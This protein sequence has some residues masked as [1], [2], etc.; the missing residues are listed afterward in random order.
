M[1]AKRVS[2]LE[3]ILLK[4]TCTL[5]HSLFYGTEFTSFWTNL[6]VLAKE[7]PFLLAH[8]LKSAYLSLL[9]FA[10]NLWKLICLLPN[11]VGN[12]WTPF[13]HG[14]MFLLYFFF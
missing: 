13:C 10:V 11:H 5:V 14:A 6:F 7:L 8:N 3:L 12:L 2:I 9:S 1:S 4:L